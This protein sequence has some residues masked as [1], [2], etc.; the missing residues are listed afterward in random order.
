[1]EWQLLLNAERL[2]AESNTLTQD[3]RSPFEKDFDR[4]VFSSAFRRLQD[5]TQVFPLSESDYVRTRLTH[6][7]E[8]SCVGRSLGTIVGRTI[9]KKHEL[10]C[11]P[12]DIG[13][14]VAAACLA[15]DLGN[16][17]LGHSGE[18]A[19][20]HWFEHSETASHIKPWIPTHLHADFKNYEGN[21]QGFRL[22][23]KTLHTDNKGGLQLTYATLGAFTKYPIESQVPE[24]KREGKA[25]AKKFGFFHSESALFEKIANRIGL[26]RRA[27]GHRWWCRHPLAFL[28]EAAD[29]ICYRIVDVEDGYRLK[30]I[31]FAE[32][33]EHFC[34]VLGE[35]PS[36]LSEIRSEKSK[37]QY[38]R[39]VTIAALVKQAA[40]AFLE[41]EEDCLKG[42]FDAE[43]VSRISA[44]PALQ[45]IKQLTINRIYSHDRVVEVE[46]AGFE[47]LGGLLDAFVGAAH[48][49]LQGRKNNSQP[50]SRSKK[51]IQ[52]VPEQFL[53]GPISPNE[54]A[55]ECLL[56]MIDFVCGMT[57]SF[58]V[59]LYKKISGISLS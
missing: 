56:S 18:D 31:S 36:R 7:L 50:D 8:V 51:I 48:T 19:I 20:R 17:P 25:G 59:S 44:A 37:V 27:P 23:T 52:L 21:A 39:A 35:I 34:A 30:L 49:L 57:D 26:I 46:A 40:T 43:L 33:H 53:A 9:C 29:D 55:Y 22:I 11:G 28:M 54:N 5:K 13:A 38:L 58:A 14:M 6:S 3:D 45:S 10:G 2:G 24:D 42:E 47:V 4:L 32:L 1:M 15:H 16:P 12:S 41:V